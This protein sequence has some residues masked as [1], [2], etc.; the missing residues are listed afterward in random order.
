MSAFD[1]KRT[2]AAQ[3]KIPLWRGFV[4]ADIYANFTRLGD[5]HAAFL[6][7]YSD[8]QKANLSKDRDAKPSGPRLLPD[9]FRDAFKDPKI[10]GLPNSRAAMEAYGRR[11]PTITA[12]QN[13]QPT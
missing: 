1:P 10:A 6:S 2:H 11:I 5:V 9:A 7:V 13:S 12:D 4:C 8:Q 3:Q